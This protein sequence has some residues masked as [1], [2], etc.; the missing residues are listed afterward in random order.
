MQLA[1]KNPVFRNAL[2]MA[3]GRT[4]EQII[5]MAQQMAQQRGVDLNQVAQQLGMQLPK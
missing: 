1:Q 2:N 3:N 4:P 5:G